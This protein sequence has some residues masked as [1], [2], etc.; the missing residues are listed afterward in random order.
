M[1]EM[2]IKVFMIYVRSMGQQLSGYAMYDGRNESSFGIC[3]W[4]E[5]ILREDEAQEVLQGYCIIGWYYKFTWPERLGTEWVT[6]KSWSLSATAEW[7]VNNI[8]MTIWT[9]DSLTFGT[10]QWR[11]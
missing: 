7:K 8:P 4:S 9:E 5:F 3:G 10:Y 11:E 6:R 2:S 1:G